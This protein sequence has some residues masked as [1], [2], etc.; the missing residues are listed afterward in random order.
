MTK[1][2]LS[3]NDKALACVFKQGCLWELMCTK[4]KNKF[5]SN[6]KKF[7]QIFFKLINFR[8]K[9]IEKVFG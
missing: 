9:K 2:G 7:I 1:I 4:I 3:C 5:V 8:L 6:L